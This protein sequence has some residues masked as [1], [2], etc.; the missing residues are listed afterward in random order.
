LRY[1]SDTD[2]LTLLRRSTSGFVLERVVPHTGSTAA[3]FE[4]DQP[5]LIYFQE[6]S[7]SKKE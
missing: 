3:P 1:I 4:E 7:T 5:E 6:I 2:N